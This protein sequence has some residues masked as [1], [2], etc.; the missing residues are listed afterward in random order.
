VD[1]RKKRGGAA[2]VTGAMNSRNLCSSTRTPRVRQVEKPVNAYY[3]QHTYSSSPSTV[4][5]EEKKERER[6]WQVLVSCLV[7][8]QLPWLKHRR[9]KIFVVGIWR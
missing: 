9:K 5:E 6:I 8:K 7:S 2:A 4:S 1:G 3:Y